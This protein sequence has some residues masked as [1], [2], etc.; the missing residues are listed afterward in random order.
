MY[1]KRRVNQCPCAFINVHDMSS[2]VPAVY[3]PDL[4]LADLQLDVYDV[5][6]RIYVKPPPKRRLKDRGVLAVWLALAVA[7]AAL[8]V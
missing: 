5:A 8:P 6:V 1:R 4:P 7:R 3:G 2:T